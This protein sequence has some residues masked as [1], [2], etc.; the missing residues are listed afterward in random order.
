MPKKKRQLTE[1][2]KA[3]LKKGQEALKK[4]REAQSA[5]KGGE[6]RRS[7]IN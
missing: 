5:K 7:V 2:Q 4:K 3:G 1:A 6:S